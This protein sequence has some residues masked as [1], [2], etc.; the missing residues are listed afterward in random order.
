MPCK[1]PDPLADAK[2]DPPYG[3]AIY[4]IGVIGVVDLGFYF[5]DPRVGIFGSRF[6][7]DLNPEAY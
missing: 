1:N 2:E 3:S 4:T 7:N 6:R 5:L